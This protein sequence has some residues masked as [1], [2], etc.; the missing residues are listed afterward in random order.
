MPVGLILILFSIAA[1]EYCNVNCQFDIVF[2][3]AW[4]MKFSTSF[5]LQKIKLHVPLIRIF[6]Q[7]EVY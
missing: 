5:L 7:F 3:S 2:E 6:F 1:L 4:E